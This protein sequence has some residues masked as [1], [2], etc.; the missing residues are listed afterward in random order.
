M[1]LQ[2]QLNQINVVTSNNYAKDKGTEALRAWYPLEFHS[3]EN[4][5]NFERQV[6]NDARSRSTTRRVHVKAGESR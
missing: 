4:L 1:S 5:E 3:M 6:M 2:R